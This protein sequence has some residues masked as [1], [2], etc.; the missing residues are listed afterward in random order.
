MA[1]PDSYA[2]SRDEKE[3]EKQQ[4]E[5]EKRE[6]KLE[7]EREKQQRENEKRVKGYAR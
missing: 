2:A 1:E 5:N 3:R 4:M 6:K 7:K